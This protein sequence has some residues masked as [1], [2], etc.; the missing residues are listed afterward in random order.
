MGGRFT[1]DVAC[2]AAV[3]ALFYDFALAMRL[4]GSQLLKSIREISKLAVWVVLRK[5][6]CQKG[7]L[8]AEVLE[9]T[10]VFSQGRR[11]CPSIRLC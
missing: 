9:F 1:A 10:G 2:D 4:T 3:W 8:E 7:S 6:M 11:W 5:S